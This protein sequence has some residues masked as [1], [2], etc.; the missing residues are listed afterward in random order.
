MASFAQKKSLLPAILSPNFG[1][2]LGMCNNDGLVKGKDYT[3]GN[4]GDNRSE[5]KG[6]CINEGKVEGKN[7]I[8]GNVGWNWKKIINKNNFINYGTVNG[9][10]TN[11]AMKKNR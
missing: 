11:I 5:I 4:I 7:E 8:G 1:E 9:V 10:R 3:G 2:I 6:Y